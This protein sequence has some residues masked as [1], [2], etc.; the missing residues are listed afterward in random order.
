MLLLRSPSVQYTIIW[1]GMVYK[2]PVTKLTGENWG[3]QPISLATISSVNYCW[4]WN[5]SWKPQLNCKFQRKSHDVLS[6]IR[7]HIKDT[8][9]SAFL[10]YFCIIN[11][12]NNKLDFLLHT[13]LLILR[14]RPTPNFQSSSIPLCLF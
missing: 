2:N 12:S 4:G 7:D 6:N 14:D 8:G 9:H 1:K 3:Y 11:R 5:A 13:S 10:N